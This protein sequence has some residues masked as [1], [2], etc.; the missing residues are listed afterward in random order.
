MEFTVSM[1]YQRTHKRLFI[2]VDSYHDHPLRPSPPP[3]SCLS[4]PPRVDSLNNQ[5][6]RSK[7]WSLTLPAPLC[8]AASRPSHL[9]LPVL[10]IL[11]AA[12]GGC[13]F[14]VI[15]KLT[16]SSKL[17]QK[18][19][20]LSVT[21]RGFC[22][23]VLFN[24]RGKSIRAQISR[25]DK[26]QNYHSPPSVLDINFPTFIQSRFTS[27]FHSS[28]PLDALIFYLPQMCLSPHF[29][30]PSPL[31]DALRSLISALVLFSRFRSTLL[32]PLPCLPST[33]GQFF[34]QHHQCMYA[35]VPHPAN[36]QPKFR[37]LVIAIRSA[38]SL[39]IPPQP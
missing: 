18:T 15:W 17:Y 7:H 10:L 28:R 37:S 16:E 19:D 11:L 23:V 8:P 12:K 20:E 32:Y 9:T 22:F 39:S 3:W 25:R 38:F 27:F 29:F 26:I 31:L 1:F 36:G 33:R 34:L 24:F 35:G 6:N 14:S 21:Y 13:L 30:S 5:S 2:T 4:P